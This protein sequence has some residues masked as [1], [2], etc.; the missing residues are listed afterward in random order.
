[1]RLDLQVTDRLNVLLVTA[2]GVPPG[3]FLGTSPDRRS[4]WIDGIPPAAAIGSHTVTL[5]ASAAGRSVT[6]VFTWDIGPNG[7]PVLANPGNQLNAGGQSVGLQLAATPDPYGDPIV[8]G[9]SPSLHLPAGLTLN[10]ATG[11]IS[12]T[13][14]FGVGGLLVVQVTAAVRGQTVSQTFVWTIRR[15]DPPTLTNPGD[16]ASTVGTGVHLHLVAVDPNGDPLTYGVSSSHP[17]PPGLSLDPATGWIRGSLSARLAAPASPCGCRTCGASA[18][19]RPSPGSSGIRPRLGT[20]PIRSAPPV[21]TSACRLTPR[22]G[23]TA[24]V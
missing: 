4:W 9:V 19:R 24:I 7:P 17:L 8:F 12:G 18:R 16:Q 13:I 11:V 3:L 15:N 1:M 5:V 20:S 21:T 10:P 6:Q 14:P 2:S 23:P 22:Q